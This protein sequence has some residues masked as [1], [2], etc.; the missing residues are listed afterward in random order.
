MWEKK[1]NIGSKVL[2]FN[3][4]YN[5]PFIF[6][7]SI[8]LSRTLLWD[9][10]IKLIVLQKFLFAIFLFN[11]VKGTCQPKRLIGSSRLFIK[12]SNTSQFIKVLA[13]TWLKETQLPGILWEENFPRYKIVFICFLK[14]S[15]PY[16]IYKG[17]SPLLLSQCCSFWT[18]IS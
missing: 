17:I 11:G 15:A 4:S 6:W 7:T 2:E 8:S 12:S 1:G 10:D 3:W 5:P 18:E 14:V 9:D 13:Y 16:F